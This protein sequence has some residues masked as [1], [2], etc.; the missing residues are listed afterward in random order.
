[1]LFDQ[2]LDLH[3]LWYMWSIVDL[4][5]KKDEGPICGFS[6]VFRWKKQGI[7]QEGHFKPTKSY[8]FYDCCYSYYFSLKNEFG[9]VCP[10]NSYMICI[11]INTWIGLVN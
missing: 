4:T 2:Y 8:A 10:Y 11:S 3:I 7:P 9:L 5:L 6:G 1:M